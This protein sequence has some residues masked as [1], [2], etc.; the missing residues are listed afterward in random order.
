MTNKKQT[1]EPEQNGV[2]DNLAK[3]LKE[4]KKTVAIV[5]VT[6][7]II[8]G[9]F[10]VIDSLREKSYQDQWSKIF[11]AEMAV[12]NG[13]DQ[14]S[15]APLEEF[16]NKY[17]KKPA[18]VYA[19]FVLGTALAQQG[20]FLK[21]ELFYKQA[22]DYADKDFAAMIANALIANTLELG[23]F[24][25]A[26]NLADEFIAKNPTHFS[27]PQIKIYKALAMELSGNIDGA[28]EMYKSIEA[29]YPQ[30]YYAAIA[31][32]K[33]TPPAPKKEPKKAPAKKTSKKAAK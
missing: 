26:V 21:A 1:Q 2:I 16:A 19:S 30:T 4:N 3:W 17:K 33:L 25:R 31:A 24:E 18:G 27:V 29:D 14:S 28:K 5:A 6:A 22:L 20:E 15:Y 13:G 32:A 10:A 11:I 8:G 9:I 7:V 23:D 12:A